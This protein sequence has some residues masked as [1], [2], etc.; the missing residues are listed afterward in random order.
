MKRTAASD[1]L[2]PDAGGKIEVTCANCGAAN[3]PGRKFCLECGAS[4]ASGCPTC[5]AANP[6]AAKFCGECGTRLGADQV[7]SAG[8]PSRTSEPAA[9]SSAPV[10]ERRMVTVLF[11]DLVEFTS[12][13]EHR[14]AEEVRDLLS[15]Y[16]DLA[17]E[18]VERHGGT[19]EKFIGDAVMAVWG[20]PTSHEDDAE[21]AAGAAPR[22]RERRAWMWGRPYRLAP[23]C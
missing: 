1:T 3:D 6:A 9:V 16:F 22:A 17:R 4:L 5:G 20:T 10:A 14:D 21:R 18:I 7:G 8:A 15:T 19:V 11:A 13:A 2:S 23:V 12:L